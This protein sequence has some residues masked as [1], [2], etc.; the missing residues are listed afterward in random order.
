M[1]FQALMGGNN[2]RVCEAIKTQERLLA[3]PL[4]ASRRIML[5]SVDDETGLCEVELRSL[6]SPEL[7]R[8]TLKRS[9][10]ADELE[11][12]FVLDHIA[13]ETQLKSGLR[14]GDI[15]VE[16]L[17]TRLDS[18]ES[19]LAVEPVSYTHLTLPTTD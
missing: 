18:D 8:I 12:T 11:A 13:Q 17:D 2:Q 1:K 19:F 7:H 3:D 10:D 6:P 16:V 9:S 4:R 14:R 5:A 15:L